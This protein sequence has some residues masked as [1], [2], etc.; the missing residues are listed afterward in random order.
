MGRVSERNLQG[1]GA[2][3]R[4]SEGCGHWAGSQ[5]FLLYSQYAENPDWF[6]LSER[7]SEELPAGAT[8]ASTIEVRGC[9]NTLTENKGR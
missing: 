9:A 1:V 2:V 6:V 8:N 4:T 3:G 5:H 7:P